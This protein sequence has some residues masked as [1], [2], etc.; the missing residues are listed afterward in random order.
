MPTIEATMELIDTQDD[1]V[2]NG[3]ECYSIM[4]SVETILNQVMLPKMTGLELLII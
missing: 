2:S 1:V 4:T 3:E